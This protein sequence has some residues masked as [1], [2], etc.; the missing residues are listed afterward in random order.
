MRYLSVIF[1]T[2][3]LVSC[4]KERTVSDQPN[5]I[6]I[7]SDDHRYDFMGF[8]GKV[9][10]LKTPGMDRLAAEGAH[11]LNAFVSTSLCSPSRAS[12]LSGQYT[13]HHQV[14]DNQSPIADSVRFFPEYLQSAGYQTAF[15]GKWHMG[16]EDDKPRKG[17]DYWVSFKGQGVYYNP[18]L[19][20][21]G[22]EKKFSDSAYV[23]DVLTDCALTFI[24]NRAHDKPFFLY[25]SHKGVHAE[26]QPA[27]RHRGIFDGIK[28]AYPPSMF[29]PGDAR[30]K[31]DTTTYDYDEVPRWVKD[32]RYSWHG[33]DYMYHGAISF[34]SFY[35]KYCETLLGVDESI[36]SVLKYLEDH[37]LMKNTIVVYMGDNGFSFGE[38]GLIDK[39]HAYEESMRVPLLAMGKGIKPGTKITEMIQNI[40][41]A[42]TIL[43]IAGVP[44]PGNMD[45]RSF[46]ALLHG[47][48]TNWRDTICYEYFWER[49]FPQTPTVYAIRT[50]RYKYIRYHGIW[51]INEFYDLQNDPN[52]MH[53]L[54]RKPEHQEKIKVLN[55]SLFKWLEETNGMN[56]PLREDEGTRSDHKFK[57][58]Y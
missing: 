10:E 41:I 36:Q 57:G 6:F 28:V 15:I 42:P 14:V 5:I 48:K 53:N 40:D 8:M 33:V 38:H 31:N 13:H 26:F 44:V 49:P 18:T 32:Q 9:P 16:H 19:N 56:M 43:S 27:Q 17:F 24:K 20:V 21:N 2:A 34:E 23:S 1:F 11:L 46:E 50:E 47:E 3:T 30:G 39:R 35:Q 25:L 22:E 45:G 58:T 7:L 12:I 55:H 37:D 29:P 51:D 4:S 54:I 52:E